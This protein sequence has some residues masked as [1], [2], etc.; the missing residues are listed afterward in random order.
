[1]KTTHIDTLYL[2]LDCELNEYYDILNILADTPSLGSSAGKHW[3]DLGYCRIGHSDWDMCQTS[4]NYPFTIQYTFEYLYQTSIIDD[5]TNLKLPF[6]LDINK[7]LVK[8]LDLNVT[9]IKKDNIMDMLFI[10]KYFK[11]GNNYYDGAFNN[12]TINLGLRRTGKTFRIY[13]KSKELND[14]KN[15]IKCDMIKDK[16]GTLDNLYSIE[17]EVHRKYIISRTD[18]D[19]SLAE[20]T[21]VIDIAKTML[22][23]VQYCKNTPANKKNILNKHYNRVK[24]N[25]MTDYIDNINFIDIKKYKKNKINLLDTMMKVLDQYNNYDGEKLSK[26]ELAK[27]IIDYDKIKSINERNNNKD[28]LENQIRKDNIL[29]SSYI[30]KIDEKERLEKEG[31]EKFL[32]ELQD[33]Q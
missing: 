10:S 8:R 29:K 26:D 25:N 28:I 17:V 18:S 7:Y 11:K 4:K 33:M 1:M 16:F 19:G 9:M 30:S 27:L 14:K 2:S 24:F 15:F 31:N 22:G 6:D 20:W 3:Y 32:K 13:N 5:V 21:D 23:S 12:E